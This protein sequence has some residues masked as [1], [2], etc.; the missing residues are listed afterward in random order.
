MYKK[1]FDL[2]YKQKSHSLR[3][4]CKGEK[5]ETTEKK[6]GELY[7]KHKKDSYCSTALNLGLSLPVARAKKGI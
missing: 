2:N 7:Q 1:E 4:S 5:S 3:L 6:G